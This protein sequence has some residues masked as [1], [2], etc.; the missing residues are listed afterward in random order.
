MQ[1]NF[2]FFWK[3]GYPNEIYSQLYPSK[4]RENKN[5]FSNVRQYVLYHKALLFQD[6]EIA[7]KIL[8]TLDPLLFEQYE[9]SIRNFNQN[10]WD[11]N[12]EYI[13]AS[14]TYYKFSQNSN[15][16][17]TICQTPKDCVFVEA[18]PYNRIWGI[19]YDMYNAMNNQEKWGENLYGKIINDVKLL[20]LEN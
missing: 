15:L 13:V 3:I 2:V 4:F 14:G 16:R 8:T 17:N 19:G 6:N 5:V 10:R 1:M 18:N 20:L 9:K 11:A 12:K 7:E